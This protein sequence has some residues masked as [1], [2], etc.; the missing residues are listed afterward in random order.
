[1][2]ASAD[3]DSS[4]PLFA[5]IEFGPKGGLERNVAARADLPGRGGE[6]DQHR[7]APST[8]VPD[9][10]ADVGRWAAAA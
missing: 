5:G 10:Q 6:I 9:I 7:V 4:A 8:L 1:L 2:A 3:R